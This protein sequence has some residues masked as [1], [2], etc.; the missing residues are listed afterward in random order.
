MT[1]E[2]E[3]EEEGKKNEIQG[4]KRERERG[5]RR[6]EEEYKSVDVERGGD[7]M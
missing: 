5:D 4:T 3:E 7:K 1:E 6:V 2:E